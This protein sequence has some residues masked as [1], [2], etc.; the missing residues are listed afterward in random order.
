MALTTHPH[1]TLRFK[2]RTCMLI[3]TAISGGRDVINEE[4]KNSLE[5]KDLT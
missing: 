5:Y 1:P 3:D 2:T 4:V